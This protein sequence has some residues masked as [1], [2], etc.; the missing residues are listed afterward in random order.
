MK[1]SDFKTR[2]SK[3]IRNRR[4][5]MKRAENCQN[6][7]LCHIRVHE[8][9]IAFEFVKS[10]G[11]QDGEEAIGPWHVYSNPFQPYTCAWLAMAR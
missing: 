8:D 9:S 4:N 6:A 2:L 11:H 5:L 3:H 10:K 7:K 1:H